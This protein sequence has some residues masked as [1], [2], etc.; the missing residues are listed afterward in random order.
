[1]CVR[2]R[3]AAPLRPQS[4]ARRELPF[5]VGLFGG[6]VAVIWAGVLVRAGQHP[7]HQLGRADTFDGSSTW[8]A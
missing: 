4:S 3:G 2:H 1:L 8:P 7:T 6:V 5:A